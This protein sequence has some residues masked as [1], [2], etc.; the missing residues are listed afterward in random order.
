MK[1]IWIKLFKEL[2]D[3]IVVYLSF[4]SWC[5]KNG[6]VVILYILIYQHSTKFSPKAQNDV[7]FPVNEFTRLREIKFFISTFNF[8]NRSISSNRYEEWKSLLVM[9]SK[10]HLWGFQR[11]FRSVPLLLHQSFPYNEY[12]WRWTNETMAC[13]FKKIIVINNG[14][15]G[16]Q[17]CCIS[18]VNYSKSS[19][20]LDNDTSYN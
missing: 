20:F 6:E 15:F 19:V 17:D 2:L 7:Y 8:W 1:F 3:Y 4:W 14:F 16:F 13:A 9:S 18:M 5:F 10:I 11:T 12:W